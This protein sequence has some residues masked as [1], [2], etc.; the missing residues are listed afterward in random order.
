[1][2]TSIAFGIFPNVLPS[3]TVQNLSLTIHNAATAEHRLIVV[4]P[5]KAKGGHPLILVYPRHGHRQSVFRFRV[6]PFRWQSGLACER[7]EDRC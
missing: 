6:P 5:Q 2:L 3:N 1:M 7:P 4:A